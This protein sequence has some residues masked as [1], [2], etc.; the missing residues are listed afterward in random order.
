MV[1]GLADTC[2]DRE[3]LQELEEKST[4]T[5]G[6]GGPGERSGSSVTALIF[7]E[8]WSEWTVKGNIVDKR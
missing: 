1:N 8:K 5:L 2:T 3:G 6:S 4:W 7:S